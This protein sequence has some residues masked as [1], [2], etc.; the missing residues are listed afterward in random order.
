VLDRFPYGVYFA[1]GQGKV[2]VVAVMNLRQHPDTWRLS[3]R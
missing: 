3:D 2:D 1:T